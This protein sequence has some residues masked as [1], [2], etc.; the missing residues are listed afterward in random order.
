M[1]APRTA[2][3][4]PLQG[5]GLRTQQRLLDA[6]TAVFAARG[7]HATRVDD[8]VEAAATSHGTFYLYFPSKEA[9]LDELIRTVHDELAEVVERFPALPAPGSGPNRGAR[10][11]EVL[12]AWL[13]EFLEFV[14]ARR[15]VIEV[16]TET[17][18]DLVGEL[19]AAIAA[20]VK[21]PKRAGLEPQIA[22]MAVAALVERL[23]FLAST[24]RVPADRDQI[25]DELCGIILAALV[26]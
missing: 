19:S 9:L 1:A 6:A 20:K 21:I 12:G 17:G 7:F 8:I 15:K 24:G 26:S 13:G 3:G 18:G 23:A 4:R 22:A 10:S 2:A 14:S 5:R 25:I 16:W 11:A